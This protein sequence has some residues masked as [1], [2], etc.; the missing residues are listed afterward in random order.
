[1]YYKLPVC[2]SVHSHTH[3]HFQENAYTHTYIHTH[4]HTYIHTYSLCSHMLY[5]I[6]D[7]L[8][9]FYIICTTYTFYILHDLFWTEIA[10]DR[11]DHFTYQRWKEPIF[12]RRLQF[13]FISV[14]MCAYIRVVITCSPQ[15]ESKIIWFSKK[16]S[17]HKNNEIEVYMYVHT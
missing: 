14:C 2:A 12:W 13:E 16:H 17:V 5:N 1:M 4:I 11:L 7:G 10:H 8:Q 15:K 3:T 6:C 9:L